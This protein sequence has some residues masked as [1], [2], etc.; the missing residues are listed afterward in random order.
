VYAIDAD[1]AA[2]IFDEER[3]LLRTA[4]W[5]VPNGIRRTFRPEPV[6]LRN[7][8]TWWKVADVSDFVLLLDGNHRFALGMRGCPEPIPSRGVY[9][10]LADAL[11]MADWA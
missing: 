2:Q 3:E 4:R 1:E 5:R 9:L 11:L 10:D 8:G 7:H 6:E